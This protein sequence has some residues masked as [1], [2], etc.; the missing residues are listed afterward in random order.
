MSSL[1]VSLV[2]ML[3]S[4]AIANCILTENQKK[5]ILAAHNYYR[6]MVDPIATDMYRMVRSVYTPSQTES[7]SPTTSLCVCYL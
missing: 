5:E 7:L 1:L 6:G 3:F 4:V 2:A